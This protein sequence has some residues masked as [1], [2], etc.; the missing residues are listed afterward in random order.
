MTRPKYNTLIVKSQENHMEERNGKV[1]SL[2][3]IKKR[4]EIWKLRQEFKRDT[5]R[6]EGICD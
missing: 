3:M 4:H 2:L 1:I 6:L 5:E